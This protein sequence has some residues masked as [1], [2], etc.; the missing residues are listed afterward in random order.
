MARKLASGRCLQR[1]YGGTGSSTIYRR[2]PEVSAGLRF[3]ALCFCMG[4]ML[5]GS[6]TK[7]DPLL[8]QPNNGQKSSERWIVGAKIQGN[9]NA[10]LQVDGVL[11]TYIFIV[12]AGTNITQ[13]KLDI[14]VSKGA[15]ITPNPSQARDYSYGQEFTVTAETGAQQT[16]RFVVYKKSV[17][18]KTCLVSRVEAMNG[19]Y[20]EFFYDSRGRVIKINSVMGAGDRNVLTCNYEANGTLKEAFISEGEGDP[21]YREY[22]S[23][24]ENGKLVRVAIRSS[25]AIAIHT[26]VDEF[27]Q[28]VK[29]DYNKT[30]CYSYYYVNDRVLKHTRCSQGNV[31]AYQFFDQETDPRH[32][33]AGQMFDPAF[34]LIFYDFVSPFDS[35][36]V[37]KYHYGQFLPWKR[38]EYFNANAALTTSKTMEYRVNAEG[39]PKEMD[40]TTEDRLNTDFPRKGSSYSYKFYYTNCQ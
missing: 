16:Y 4:V 19:W 27:N 36:D 39:F 6:C 9:S 37:F 31:F 7:N 8:V 32:F 2:R 11:S 14:E 28:I 5:L 21:P 29:K 10:V 24:I 18:G 33:L 15:V 34:L 35:D 25:P 22:R 3:L 12:P 17:Y 20:L 13:L 26:E 30:I 40:I 23:I 1:S 38:N